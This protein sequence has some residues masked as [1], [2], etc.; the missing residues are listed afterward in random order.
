MS[1]AAVGMLVATLLVPRADP[2]ETWR[3]FLEIR[4]PNKS[5]VHLAI[6]DGR[7]RAV[8]V[9]G[10]GR[11]AF[12]PTVSADD[13]ATVRITILER[14]EE[15]WQELGAFSVDVGGPFVDS[16]TSPS[17]GVRVTHLALEQTT[18]W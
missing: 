13:H 15:G 3:A 4:L 7:R 6:R 11:F 14:G 16:P 2:R 9:P 17:F 8:E 12:R 18:R 1:G 5:V 10:V